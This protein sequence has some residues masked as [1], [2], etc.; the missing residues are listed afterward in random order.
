MVSI[1]YKVFLFQQRDKLWILITA[2]TTA[3]PHLDWVSV[4]CS[5]NSFARGRRTG[6]TCIAVLSIAT[7]V[8]IVPT[9]L[10]VACISQDNNNPSRAI[11]LKQKTLSLYQPRPTATTPT[12]TS[13]IRGIK[14]FM[15][16][17]SINICFLLIET[18]TARKINAHPPLDSAFYHPQQD[19]ESRSNT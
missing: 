8:G 3:P 2:A 17:M 7:V 18:S 9:L 13:S 11:N 5:E 19:S 4:C 14:K 10:L 15:L 16:I 12:T 1:I 6:T